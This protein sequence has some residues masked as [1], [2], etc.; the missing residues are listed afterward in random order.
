[1][2]TSRAKTQSTDQ[3]GKSQQ[4]TSAT[5]SNPTTQN[6]I[7]RKKHTGETPMHVAAKRSMSLT[8]FQN[9]TKDFSQ[10]E[11][12]QYSMKTSNKGKIPI[13]LIRKQLPK[14]D[15]KEIFDILLDN[16]IAQPVQAL[17][18]P[19]DAQK[20]RNKY[21]VFDNSQLGQNIDAACE[22]V[23][24]IR[25]LVDHST[26]HPESNKL[27]AARSNQIGTKLTTRRS[28]VNNSVNQLLLREGDITADN[29][30]IF[31]N[32]E[33]S[34]REKLISRYNQG[35]D[36]D[37]IGN[38][39]EMARYAATIARDKNLKMSIY[40]FDPQ[41]GDHVFG[42][43]LDKKKGGNLLT[44]CGPA[45]VIC[46]SWTPLVCL[47]R[48]YKT[49]LKDHRYFYRGGRAYEVLTT[50]N[51]HY[52]ILEPIYNPATESSLFFPITSSHSLADQFI[53]PLIHKLSPKEKYLFSRIIRGH[54]DTA[55]DEHLIDDLDLENYSSDE[56]LDF[57]KNTFSNDTQFLPLTTY[58]YA[59]NEAFYRKKI[60]KALT[61]G[62]NP[63][64]ADLREQTALF[65]AS[66]KNYLEIAK[67]LL[68][69]GA[70]PNQKTREGRTPLLEAVIHNNLEMAQAL[71]SAGAN[72]NHELANGDTPLSIA[73]ENNHLDMAHCLL[74]GGASP[75]P[76]STKRETH[77]AI[78]VECNDV[79]MAKLLLAAGADPN[80]T[81][82]EFD[83]PPLFIA[84]DCG[85]TEMVDLLLA[86]PGI[87][88][89]TICRSA[90][91]HRQCCQNQANDIRKRMEK[92]IADKIEMGEDPSEISISAKELAVIKGLTIIANKIEAVEK[93][94][95]ASV[96]KISLFNPAKNSSTTTENTQCVNACKK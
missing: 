37:R 8:H 46:C 58:L 20:I 47:A 22:I 50:F 14:P 48:E 6:N 35:I 62:A 79:E 40:Q 36:K 25:R 75:N 87:Q 70:D 43:I 45:S 21:Q 78:S 12:I 63:N 53:E 66:K 64:Q 83:F 90:D 91:E 30:K 54:L 51:P 68:A 89:T 2:S 10:D 44:N 61:N 80:L 88:F 17:K 38:C 69:H 52:H 7:K 65:I 92:H 3:H 41:T 93:N 60:T 67:I 94:I 29:D 95:K 33:T 85:Y 42:L 86:T 28:K 74:T 34:T 13:D 26:S 16:L 4:S 76:I 15:K 81:A 82:A 39:L 27:D 5:P 23:N 72:P 56:L 1:M 24:Y 59:D 57:L 11:K 9:L 19:I 32:L 71:L 73:V 96:V 31:V 55:L 84:T 49:Q 18:Q 77:L